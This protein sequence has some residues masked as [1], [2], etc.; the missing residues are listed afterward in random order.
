MSIIHLTNTND[1]QKSLLTRLAYL[2]I[3]FN[4]FQ[5]LKKSQKIIRISDLKSILLKPNEPY[6][7]FLHLTR[8]KHRI[9]GITTT[10]LEILEKLKAAGLGDLEIVDLRVDKKSGFNG[11]CFKDSMQ[12]FGFSFRGT[13]LKTLSSFKSDAIADIEAFLTNNTTQITDAQSL[14]N[15]HH[16]PTGQNFLYGHSLG[17][18]I[19]ERIFLQNHTKISNT[20]VINPLHIGSSLLNTPSKLKVFRS[21]Q[22]F[23]CF[24]IGGDYISSITKPTFFADNINYV[25][26]NG[27]YVNNPI[28]N[29][30]IE[31]AKFDEFGN[32]VKVPQKDAFKNYNVPQ[33]DTIINFI[34]DT[35]TK[36]FFRRIF[37]APQK[38]FTFAQSRLSKLFKPKSK[39]QP[40]DNT[41]NTSPCNWHPCETP[42]VPLHSN[43]DTEPPKEL[44]SRED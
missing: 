7:G 14:F 22:K 8:L 5:E 2:N 23:N 31:A 35:P 4:K 13:D 17:G 26:N 16:S 37:L 9:V 1:Y 21:P 40:A 33:L 18:F 25:E 32:F 15:K 20:F 29:H 34:S 38:L 41:K 42:V 11:I 6:L 24:V 27:M 12:N 3:D 44:P 43:L 30:L 39:T 36:S 28:T 10:N 19:A